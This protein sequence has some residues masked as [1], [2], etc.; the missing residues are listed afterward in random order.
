MLRVRASVDVVEKAGLYGS[1]RS[2]DLT[3]RS[4]NER[5]TKGFSDPLHMVSV[6]KRKS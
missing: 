6:R 1:F 4:H 2:F 5:N 3:G